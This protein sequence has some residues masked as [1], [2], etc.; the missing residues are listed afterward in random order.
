MG[1]SQGKSI[2]GMVGDFMGKMLSR[3]GSGSWLGKAAFGQERTLAGQ[4]EFNHCNTNRVGS[5]MVVS[6]L[7]R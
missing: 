6:K 4:T 5:R 1:G 3:C 2:P 7:N